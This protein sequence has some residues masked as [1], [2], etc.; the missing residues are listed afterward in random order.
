MRD[1]PAP[2]GHRALVAYRRAD[3][4]IRLHRAQWGADLHRQIGPATPLGGPDPAAPRTT[5]V[6]PEPILR[7]A[8]PADVLAAVDRSTESLIVVTPAGEAETVLVC[9]VGFPVLDGGAA[10]HDGGATDREDDGSADDD[11]DPS[12][13]FVVPRGDSTAFRRWFVALRSHLSA[14]VGRD[15]L[16][17]STARAVLEAAL[18]GR[19]TVHGPDDPSFLRT[20]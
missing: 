4:S 7:R 16:A 13:L 9:P 8:D 2:M 1:H 12:W 5:V 11:A 17:P 19:G 3:G 18:S 14:A 6:G 15:A 20:A 10:D